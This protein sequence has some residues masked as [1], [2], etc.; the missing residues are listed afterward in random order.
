MFNLA[1]K[2]TTNV[3]DAGG[4][5]LLIPASADRKISFNATNDIAPALSGVKG[6]KSAGVLD[7]LA[8][9]LTI[10]SNG[11]FELEFNK[12]VLAK[13]NTLYNS[14]TTAWASSNKPFF[15]G[16]TF[17]S[18]SLKKMTL[19]NFT[20]ASTTV[21]TGDSLT[22]TKT[23]VKDLTGKSPDTDYK[24]TVVSDIT[25]PKFNS[26]AVQSAA[27]NN[28]VVTL[29]FSKSVWWGDTTLLTDPAHISA[30]ITKLDSSTEARTI[31]TINARAKGSASMTLNITFAGAAITDGQ[32]VK[33]TIT[34]AGAALIKDNTAQENPLD[35]TLLFKEVYY[36]AD[37]TP[38]TFDGLTVQKVALDGNEIKLTFNEP[39]W[40][41]S[42]LA[43]GDITVTVAGETRTLTAIDGGALNT[44]RLKTS[45]STTINITINGAA[46]TNGQV[47]FVAITLA[48][49][50]KIKDNS[51]SENVMQGTQN[52][53]I[54]ASISASPNPSHF[55]ANARTKTVTIKG[56]TSN[57][58]VKVFKGADTTASATV[59]LGSTGEGS[60][61]L[62]ELLAG[63]SMSYSLTEAGKIES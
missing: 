34:P 54:T 31:S 41:S 30:L 55:F 62:S 14:S 10:I 23:A 8:N 46:I 39:V 42:G 32:K 7:L 12:P 43:A 4:G 2:G 20:E 27:Y 33:I 47:V 15:N 44:P 6:E 3:F 49:S 40:W 35:T 59:I 17:P 29:T 13:A 5:N 38:P 36:A 18:D 58:T 56:S 61:S 52:K 57:A 9:G 21:T 37:T 16:A 19:T 51:Y 60:A 45:A 25:P 48:G 1:T 22:V 53:S 63:T 24:F 26:I 28:N 11:K 50:A